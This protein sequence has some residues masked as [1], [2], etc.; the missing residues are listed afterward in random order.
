[1]PPTSR[2]GTLYI[3]YIHPNTLTGAQQ[4]L[5]VEG[6]DAQEDRGTACANCSIPP[7]VE[8]VVYIVFP[9]FGIMLGSLFCRVQRL[10]DAN[11][12]VASFTGVGLVVIMD[13]FGRVPDA[14]ALFRIP[15]MWQGG[16]PQNLPHV[17]RGDIL[18]GDSEPPSRIARRYLGWR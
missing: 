17:S 9:S 4:Y 15:G 1:M 7:S 8:A 2:R 6:S 5:I 18:D 11:R 16:S 13:G 3:Y 12:E 14:H 10:A